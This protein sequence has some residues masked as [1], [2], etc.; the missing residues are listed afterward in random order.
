MSGSGVRTW[1]AMLHRNEHQSLNCSNVEH[2][3]ERFHAALSTCSM[4]SVWEGK[5]A[6]HGITKRNE[7][8]DDDSLPPP[9][10]GGWGWV[11]VFGSFM[12]HIVSKWRSLFNISSFFWLLLWTFV[13]G[14]TYPPFDHF[15][16]TIVH[17]TAAYLSYLYLSSV[18]FTL[19]VFHSLG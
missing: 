2:A 15:L 9:P 5:M 16:L 11:V 6:E 1:Q 17:T 7:D 19:Q 14:V 8:D 10:D 3:F 18:L 4:R 13:T 12:I